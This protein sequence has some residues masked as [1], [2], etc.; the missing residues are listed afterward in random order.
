DPDD[1]EV[2]DIVR[3]VRARRARGHGDRGVNDET[4]PAPP[5]GS[6]GG[7]IKVDPTRVTTERHREAGPVHVGHQFWR[8]LGLD[9]ILRD[10]KLSAAARDLA[11]AMTLNRLI[12]PCSEHAMPDWIRRTASSRADTAYA[13]RGGVRDACFTDQGWKLVAYRAPRPIYNLDKLAAWPGSP[14]WLFEGPRKAD[15]A[16]ACFPGAVT[17]AN[18]GGANAI[19]QTDLAPLRGRNLSFLD[20]WAT[21][22]AELGWTDFDLFGADVS[23]PEIAWLNSGLLWSSPNH[24]ILDLR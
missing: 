13:R 15:R 3:R 14:V 20:S 19:K 24:S 2:A 8:R 1:G 9:D 10:C 6:S 17:S 7:L 16:E 4:L 23:R 12:A 22:A 21:K 5:Q 18:A 11:C